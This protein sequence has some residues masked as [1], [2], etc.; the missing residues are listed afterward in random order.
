[1][2]APPLALQTTK[3]LINVPRLECRNCGRVLQAATPNLV[4]GCNY[5]RAFA[6]LVVSLRPMMTIKDIAMYLGVSESMIRGIDKR[7]RSKRPT[8]SILARVCR[9]EP[10]LPRFPDFP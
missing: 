10:G 4:P 3:L 7:Y 1:M 6:R 5:T 8:K 9:L 2:V